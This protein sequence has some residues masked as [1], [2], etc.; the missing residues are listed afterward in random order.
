MKKNI[1]LLCCTTALASPMTHASDAWKVNTAA[2]GTYLGYSNSQ[3]RDSL[4]EEGAVVSADYLD[5]GGVTAGYTHTELT[6]KNNQPRLDQN[7][8]FLSARKHF[9]IDELAGKITL[10][11]DGHFIDN[12]DPS[13]DTDD[14]SVG[15]TQASYLSNNKKYYADFG[16]AYSHYQNN[17]HVSQY[18]PTVGVGVFDGDGWLQLRGYFIE[19]SNPTRAQGLSSTQAAEIKY[20]HWLT[21]DGLFKPSNLQIGGLVGRRFYA[22]DMDAGTVAN[23]ADVQT[24]GITTGAEWKVGEHGKVL[25]LG[26]NNFYKNRTAS[27]SYSGAFGY[28]N[29]NVAW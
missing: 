4:H 14:V 5:E 13:N 27:D 1:M 10:R 28:L 22:V 23:L 8:Y 24:G 9:Y 26:G 2:Q 11:A 16:Y 25:L 18:T 19:T 17:L 3:Y 7:S 29:A 20:T 15:A 21:P 12:T 6:L